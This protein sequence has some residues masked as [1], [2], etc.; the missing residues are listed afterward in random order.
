MKR[1]LEEALD[2]VK[3]LNT[4]KPSEWIPP[5]QGSRPSTEM[6]L[7]SSFVENT[8]GYIE[9]VI[10]QINGCYEQGWF[11]GCA[12]MI[13]KVLE[14]LIIECFEA[15]GISNKIKDS[16]DNFFQFSALLS[17]FRKEVVW[18][19]SRNTKDSLKKLKMLGDLSA[20]NRRFIAHR[21]DIDK[22]TFDFRVVVQELV[23]IS[24]MK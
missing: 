18:S 6:V 15:H 14:T 7:D 1:D 11:D 21:S 24:G 22:I 4:L 20:H 2:L 17:A 10:D 3:N 19:A 8:R 16:D 13:R 12:V 23:S 5:I 9:R